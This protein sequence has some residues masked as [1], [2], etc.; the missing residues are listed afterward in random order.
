MKVVLLLL[1]L[2]F[3]SVL[4]LKRSFATHRQ[5]D[6]ILLLY[7]DRLA[8]IIYINIIVLVNLQ[9]IQY[10]ILFLE[11]NSFAFAINFN[12]EFWLFFKFPWVKKYEN[13]YLS[14]R[15]LNSFWWILISYSWKV[16]CNSMLTILF[17]VWIRTGSKP[18]DIKTGF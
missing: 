15:I 10:T 12:K 11:K 14:H 13:N 5:I 4:R 18:P 8:I 1:N 7:K 6:I 17:W 3:I 9:K 2:N 16:V